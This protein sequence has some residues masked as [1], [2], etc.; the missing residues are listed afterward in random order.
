MDQVQSERDSL[1]ECSLAVKSVGP[2][3]ERSLV[4]SRLGEKSVD[5]PLSKA[6]NP[7]LLQECRTTMADP[8]K[9]HFFLTLTLNPKTLN[10]N[11]KVLVFLPC[12]DIWVNC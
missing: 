10:L 9:Q 8:V 2:V 6:P 5:V 4:L 11:L 1:G 12:T 3:T 7:N